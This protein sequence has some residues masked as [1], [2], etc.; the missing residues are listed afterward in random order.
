[1]I[2]PSSTLLGLDKMFEAPKPI[3]PLDYGAMSPVAVPEPVASTFNPSTTIAPPP[4]P[5]PQRGQG[6]MASPIASALMQR[7][8]NQ[9]GD[10]KIGDRTI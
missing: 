7:R 6:I 5:P 4:P 9:A 2:S 1:M 10:R 3:E 8:D